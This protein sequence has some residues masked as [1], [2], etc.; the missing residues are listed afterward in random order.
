MLRVWSNSCTLTN[1][2][3]FWFISLSILTVAL[4]F[5]SPNLDYR[6]VAFG[7]LLPVSEIF[8][9]GPWIG[10]TLIF[11]ALVMMLIMLLARGKRLIQ[12]RWLGIPIGL[13]A[14]LV[15]DATWTKTKVFWWPFM[16]TDSLG[17]SNFSEV[18]RWPTNLVLEIIGVAVTFWLWRK[19][20]FSDKTNRVAFFQ[21]GKL[22]ELRK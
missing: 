7:S 5:D 2:V 4:V 21:T 11:P 18:E 8:F 22:V 10:H 1:A 14:H 19:F 16:G 6:L 13:F 3:F 12:R 17:R 20:R 9:G 15:L